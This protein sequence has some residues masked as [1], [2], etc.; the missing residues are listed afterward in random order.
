VTAA[1]GVAAELAAMQNARHRAKL[2]IG[3]SRFCTGWAIWTEMVDFRSTMR[4]KR[5][6][7]EGAAATGDPFDTRAA[8][9]LREAY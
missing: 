6:N 9:P 2:R 4:I 3:E 5:P 1:A 8:R 7:E